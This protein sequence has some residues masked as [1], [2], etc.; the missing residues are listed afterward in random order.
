MY[1]KNNR[2]EIKDNKIVFRLL[3]KRDE[4]MLGNFF[5]G[6]S[7]EIKKWYSPHIFD[8]NE[9]HNICESIEK[10]NLKSDKQI[11]IA[12]CD[13]KIIGYCILLFSWRKW[14][15][16]RYYGKYNLKISN[17]HI[18]TIAPCVSDKYQGMGI[19]N[20][21]MQ[22]VIYVSKKYNKEVIILWGGVVVKNRKAVNY[23]KKNNFK[24]AKKWLHPIKKVMSYDM[25]LRV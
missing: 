6:L 23:Y 10:V 20:K 3:K 25:Y 14:D 18:C 16:I 7:E 5:I 1:I 17:K 19:G 13:K 15:K 4:K 2:I 12:V 11:V 24:I 8:Y 21:M 22:Y 9:A